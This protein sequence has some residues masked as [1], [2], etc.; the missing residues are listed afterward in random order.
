M[1]DEIHWRHTE[2]TSTLYPTIRNIAHRYWNA[3]SNAFEDLDIT[4]WTD[5]ALTMGEVPVNSYFYIAAMPSHADFIVNWYWI[6]IFEQEGASPI[7]DDP[8]IGTLVGYWDGTT[9]S[10]WSA[11]IKTINDNNLSAIRIALSAAQILP[12]SVDNTEFAPTTTEFESGDFEETA[13]GFYNG[14]VIIFTTGDLAGQATIIEDYS[15]EDGRGH[16]T[17][18]ELTGAPGNGDNFIIV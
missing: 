6:D 16:F 12:G 3:D 14:R 10:P 8:L 11:N 15:E 4:N 18:T 13:S 17:V 5:Y 7:V 2:S 9:F 1:A